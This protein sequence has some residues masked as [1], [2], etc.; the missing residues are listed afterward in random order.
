MSMQTRNDYLAIALFDPRHPH[1]T[2]HMK[3]V[4]IHPTNVKYPEL[5]ISSTR[6]VLT[7]EGRNEKIGGHRLFCSNPNGRL[8]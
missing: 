1:S 4:R 7:N 8:E 3:R 5:S 6:H 2:N